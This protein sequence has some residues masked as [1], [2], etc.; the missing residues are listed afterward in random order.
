MDAEQRLRELLTKFASA[1]MWCNRVPSGGNT[2]RYEIAER[3]ILALFREQARDAERYMHLRSLS[4]S[5]QFEVYDMA[6]EP[7]LLHT[8][9]LDA[10]IDAAL[11][12]G[13]KETT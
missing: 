12:A 6:K 8:E 11:S 1:A 13:N 5:N 10:A 3:A 7:L 4:D 2:E 9:Y